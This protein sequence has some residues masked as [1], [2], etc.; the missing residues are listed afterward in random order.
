MLTLEQTKYI[1]E[2]HRPQRP[3]SL[4]QK[5]LQA[6]IDV[7][8]LLIK[9]KQEEDAEVEKMLNDMAE[10]DKRKGV[11]GSG[12]IKC[13]NHNSCPDA[14]QPHAY[15]CNHYDKTEKEFAIWLADRSSKNV[16]R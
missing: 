1:L 4:K 3:R 2:E 6:A 16:E 9:E 14:F 5:E 10:A 15:S 11:I 13:P 12:C 8:L 7:A